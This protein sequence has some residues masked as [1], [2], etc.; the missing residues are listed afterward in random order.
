V[1]YLFLIIYLACGIWIGI[2]TVLS[3]IDS[4]HRRNSTLD[5]A[6]MFVI[7]VTLGPIIAA[8]EKWKEWMT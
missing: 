4:E 1:L 6:I 2:A 8:Q 7:A 5:L 3:S